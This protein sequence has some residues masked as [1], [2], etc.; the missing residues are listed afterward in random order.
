MPPAGDGSAMHGFSDD[1]AQ[2]FA[3]NERYRI[4][5]RVLGRGQTGVVR[6]GID[7]QTGDEIA[8][9][10]LDRAHTERDPARREALRREI[11]VSMR[12]QHENI[13]RLHDVVL[14]A[15]RIHLIMEIARGGELFAAVAQRGAVTEDECRTYFHQLISAVVGPSFLV[16]CATETRTLTCPLALVRVGLLPLPVGLPPGF[17]VGEHLAA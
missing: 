5:N 6:A 15:D 13:I 7:L 16:Y 2:S 8:V 9:K 1:D 17:E 11:T 4:Y 10:V 12:L 3:I 14:N